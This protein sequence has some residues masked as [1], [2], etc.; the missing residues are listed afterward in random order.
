MTLRP[1]NKMTARMILIGSA[2]VLALCTTLWAAS[3]KVLYRFHGTDGWGGGSVVLGADG[4]LYGTTAAGGTTCASPGCGVVFRL[5]RRGNGG[6][7]EAVLHNFAG[8]DGEFPVGTLVVDEAG[9]LYGTTVYGGPNG[10][11]GLGCGV[12]FELARGSGGTVRNYRIRRHRRRQCFQGQLRQARSM[13][14]DG[15]ALVHWRQRRV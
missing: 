9:T 7:H 10:C 15:A 13:D 14:R 8:S 5:T 4:S 11:S 2:L 1:A 12:A 3:E 6:W